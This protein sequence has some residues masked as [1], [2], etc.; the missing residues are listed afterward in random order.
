MSVILTVL[1]RIQGNITCY[2]QVVTHICLLPL[3]IVDYRHANGK[4]GILLELFFLV[5]TKTAT[6][7]SNQYFFRVFS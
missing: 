4:L 5:K 3:N 2:R 1:L 6:H 7:E